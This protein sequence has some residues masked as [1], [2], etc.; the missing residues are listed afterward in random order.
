MIEDIY[1]SYLTHLEGQREKDKKF[2]ASAAG[3]CFRKQLYNKYGF[4]QDKKDIKSYRYLR[5]GT[6]IHKDIENA[7]SHYNKTNKDESKKLLSEDKITLDELNVIGTYDLGLLDD[8]DNSFKLWDIKTVAA[9]KWTT[10]F[11]RI[12]NRKPGTDDHYKYQLGTYALGIHKKFE[13]NKI[14]M[15]LLWYNKNTAM[16]REQIVSPEWIDKA[17]EYWGELN[18]LEYDVGEN[19]E[20]DLIPKYFKGVPYQDWECNYCPYYSICPSDL[21]ENKKKLKGSI[22]PKDIRTS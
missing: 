19:F 13:V 10:K 5:L 12:K 16:M 18:D 9:Y 6:I 2:H 20:E 15:Y 17:L 8:E 3:S 1:H 11:G 7:V 14:S 4:P 21:R 22:A